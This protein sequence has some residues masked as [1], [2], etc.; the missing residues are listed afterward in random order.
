[1][2]DRLEGLPLKSLVLVP[3]LITLAV[4]A[5]RLIGELLHL[6]PAFFSREAGGAGAIVG[7]VWLVPIFGVLLA[8]KLLRL[9]YRP[10]TGGRALGI[11]LLALLLMPAGIAAALRVDLPVRVAVLG[12]GS[13]V[14]LLVAYQAWPAL[15]RTLLA[16]GLAARI[17]VAALMLVAMLGNWGTHYELGPPGFPEM[18]VVPRWFW[19]GLLPQL[20]FWVGFTVVVGSV[21][22]AVTALVASRRLAASPQTSVAAH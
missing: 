12:V 19:I 2:A 20:T 4:T 5:V 14:A 6:S 13:I 22:G 9:G 15:G 21:F 7:I 8:L 16:Y 3:A 17:P 11:S 10:A 1:M 18:A